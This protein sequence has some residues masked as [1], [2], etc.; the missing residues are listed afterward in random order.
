[1]HDNYVYRQ[2]PKRIWTKNVK[3]MK[4]IHLAFTI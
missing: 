4:V 3:V 2:K 1:M